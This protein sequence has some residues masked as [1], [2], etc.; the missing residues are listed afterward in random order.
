LSTTET[1]KVKGYHE[2]EERYREY[3]EDRGER[4]FSKIRNGVIIS[5]EEDAG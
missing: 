4:S 1:R 5:G 2:G 3:W